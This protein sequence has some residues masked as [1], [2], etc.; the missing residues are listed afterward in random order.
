[1]KNVSEEYSS[2]IEGI[3]SD[4]ETKEEEIG[5]LKTERENLGK[6]EKAKVS[7]IWNA[8]DLPLELF[9]IPAPPTEYVGK[10]KKKVTLQELVQRFQNNTAT[11]I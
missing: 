10:A 3:D 11:F 4:I 6:E 1:M 7:E 5:Q 9:R 2:K 8:V